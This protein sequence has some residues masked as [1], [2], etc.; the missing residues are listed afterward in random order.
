MSAFDKEMRSCNFTDLAL[1]TNP[2]H[3]KALLEYAHTSYLGYLFYRELLKEPV[4]S[5]NCICFCLSTSLQKRTTRPVL[6]FIEAYQ[7]SREQLTLRSLHSITDRVDLEDG[8]LNL[9]VPEKRHI[10]YY[11]SLLRPQV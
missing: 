7:K 6:E 3:H 2:P 1:F 11:K 5:L 4:F 9:E 10:N 8:P